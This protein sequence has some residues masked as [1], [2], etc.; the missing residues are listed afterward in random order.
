MKS[1]GI[2]D[3]N[4]Q[5]EYRCDFLS[6]GLHQSIGFQKTHT[7]RLTDGK[8]TGSRYSLRDLEKIN[9]SEGLF[10]Y[11]IGLGDVD[12][13]ALQGL[14]QVTNGT[15]DHTRNSAD[16]KDLYLR[17][18]NGYY[19]RYGNRLHD[20]GALTIRS[21][22]DGREV[23][24]NGRKV[25]VTP[26]KMDAATPG[27]YK[28]GVIFRRGIWECDAVVKRGY[29]TIIDARE[30]DLGA[31]L[32]IVSSPQGAT[33]FL[34]DAYVGIT[35]IGRP[36]SLAQ[37]DWAARAKAD[38]RQLR[39]RK[40]PYGNHRLRLRGIPDFDF[41]PDQELAVELPVKDEELILFVDIFRQKVQDGQGNI[42][43][44]GRPHDPFRELEDAANGDF[45]SEF[46]LEN[47]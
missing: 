17:V 43:A 6:S 1:I 21:I 7:K 24:H 27:D 22:P 31:D 38:T 46:D 4:Q 18:L 13:N 42:I 23:I 35:A 39:I 14:S 15:F 5:I 16:L 47:R 2:E 8:D 34:D 36:L 40:V 44:G 28:V 9:V 30:S 20:T 25:G 41:G 37:K 12:V 33:V 45:D 19:Q 3:P 26:F 29:R 10:V 32:L 11:G